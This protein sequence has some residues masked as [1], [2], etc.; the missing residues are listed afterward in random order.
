M[1]LTAFI[2]GIQAQAGKKSYFL[3]Y[4]KPQSPRQHDFKQGWK[5]EE[6]TPVKYIYNSPLPK[7]VYF[8]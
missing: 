5:Q 8:F 4:S 3:P 2:V 6:T 1:K 7:I